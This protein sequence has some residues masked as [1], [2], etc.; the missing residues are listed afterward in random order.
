M[1]ERLR[2]KL[3][4]LVRGQYYY[5]WNLFSRVSSEDVYIMSFQ[6]SGSTWVR[7][8]LTS[9]AHDAEVTPALVDQTVP[10]I[11]RSRHGGATDKRAFPHMGVFKSH[12]PYVDVPAKVVYLVRD[13]RDAMLSL[14]NYRR[15]TAERQGRAADVGDAPDFFFT[16]SVFGTWHEH[17][18]QW[19]RR[20]E[21]WPDDRYMVLRYEDLVADTERHLAALVEFVGLEVDPARIARAVAFNT[22]ERLAEIDVRSGAGALEYPAITKERW[23]SLLSPDELTRYEE[24]AGEALV[25]AGYP[26]HSGAV[27]SPNP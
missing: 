22:K 25:R 15:R 6:R 17:V 23:Q 4:R 2:R 24:L 7:C 11:N 5:D 18:L 8:L 19:L 27:A 16:R 10:D 9:Y 14:Y 3:I 1:Y 12:S 21:S 26:L 13:G 20:L